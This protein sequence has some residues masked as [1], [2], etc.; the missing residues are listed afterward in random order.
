MLA[1]ESTDRSAAADLR[2]LRT[3][4]SLFF[5][6]TS[7]REAFLKIPEPIGR[8]TNRR[9]VQLWWWN[10]H[11]VV[12]R[13]V[14]QIEEEKEVGDPQFPK[15]QWPTPQLCPSCRMAPGRVFLEIPPTEVLTLS[16]S[17]AKEN[18]NLKEVG[19]FLERYYR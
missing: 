15:S 7:C 11:N 3:V 4:I 10:A 5:G 17:V 12:N 8:S 9:D 14:Q 19:D 16:D 2:T 6:C 13:R 1:A 18:W